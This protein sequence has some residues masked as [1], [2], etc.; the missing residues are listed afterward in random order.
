MKPGSAWSRNDR[1]VNYGSG[2]KAYRPEQT[3]RGKTGTCI[4]QEHGWDCLLHTRRSLIRG[5]QWW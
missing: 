3:R 4:G 2:K 1:R 5:W